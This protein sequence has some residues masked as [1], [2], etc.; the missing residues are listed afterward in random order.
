MATDQPRLPAR[1]SLLNN[2]KTRSIAFQLALG[3]LV[4]VLIYGAVTNAIDHL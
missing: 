1:G 3:T 4:I 2:P